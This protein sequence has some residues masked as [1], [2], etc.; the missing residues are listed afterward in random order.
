MYGVEV[1]KDTQFGDVNFI[2]DAS[3]SVGNKDWELLK[4]FM[5][6]IVDNLV[7]GDEKVSFKLTPIYI[8][9]RVK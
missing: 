4:Q 8:S 6:N 5:N 3:S 9:H 2:V 7:I 1:C